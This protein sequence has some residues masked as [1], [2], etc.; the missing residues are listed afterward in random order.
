MSVH[1]LRGFLELT[2]MHGLD[3]EETLGAAGCAEALGDIDGRIP[4]QI[5]ERISAAVV[6][7]MGISGLL[8]ATAA[9]RGDRFG[10]LYYVARH[11]ATMRL[12]LSRIAKYYR[13]TS[14]LGD[15]RLVETPQ[16]ARFEL[17]QRE[18]LSVSFTRAMSTVWVTAVIAVIRQ[19][20]GQDFHPFE[21]SLE[22]PRPV[23]Q[24]EVGAHTA[25]LPYPLRFDM[26]CSAIE[27]DLRVLDLKVVDADPVL[28]TAMLRYIDDLAARIPNDATFG[29]RLG[30]ILVESIHRGDHC[31]GEAARQLG[32]TPR[33]MQR[34]LREE[35][36]SYK[37]V[38]DD[39]R[40]EIAVTQMRE[41]RV[42][43]DEIASLLGFD[44]SSSFHRAFKR[45]TGVTP[46]EFRRRA[47]T[48]PSR[49]PIAPRR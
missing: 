12:A 29:R 46:G 32:T 33:T 15:Y 20:S 22:T 31:V 42:S 47:E 35:G 27:F 34:R 30:Q 21:V 36:T 38:L 14:D 48:L 39:V 37:Q 18:F 11:S 5:A 45:W 1:A 28:E 16:S 41:R 17:W 4:W 3:V 19:L 26:P 49:M 2:A 44:K 43:A 8:R 10:P 25:V 40:Q 13:V 24:A 6:E 7:R 9:L 23:D